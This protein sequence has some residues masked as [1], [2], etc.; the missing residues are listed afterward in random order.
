MNNFVSFLG[1]KTFLFGQ[2]FEE[3]NDENESLFAGRKFKSKRKTNCFFFHLDFSDLEKKSRTFLSE[4]SH[5]NCSTALKEINN[6]ISDI[7]SY[8]VDVS[9]HSDEILSI[10]SNCSDLFVFVNENR[11]IFLDLSIDDF[12]FLDEHFHEVFMKIVQIL[13]RFNNFSQI[14]VELFELEE[15]LLFFLPSNYRSLISS[16]V[17]HR[18]AST[19]IEATSQFFTSASK[20]INENSIELFSSSPSFINSSKN[21]TADYEKSLIQL[22]KI[23]IQT[24]NIS[25]N[26]TLQLDLIDL[27]PIES[28]LSEKKNFSNFTLKINLFFF[29]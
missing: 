19:L 21:E 29:N 14:N 26:N 11:E 1:C 3:L 8:I 17:S 27:D 20:K 18:L 13:N 7:S 5:E 24:S 10:V 4:I 2:I 23:Q 6:F 22:E 15:N 16:S 9:I 28:N 12:L 25:S